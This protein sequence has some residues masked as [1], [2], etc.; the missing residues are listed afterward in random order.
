MRAILAAGGTAG[1]INPAIAIAKEII[2]REPDSVITFIG[3]EDGMESRIVRQNGFGFEPVEIHGFERKLNWAGIKFNLH[4][5][6]CVVTA[7]AKTKKIFREFKPDIVIGCGGYI[8]GPVVRKAAL[9]RIPTVIQEQNSFPGL[10]TRLLSKRVK[11]I[12]VPNED[13]MNKIGYPEKSVIVGNPVAPEIR[14]TDREKSRA[15]LGIGDRTCIVS[16]GGSLGAR[17]INDIALEMFRQTDGDDRF[18][19]IHATG[20]YDST[21]MDRL[22]ENGTEIES[23]PCRISSYINDM[24]R[25]LAA[26]DLVVCR[27]GATTLAEVE[28]AGKAS[29]LVPSPHVTANHQ[30]YNALTLAECG[31]AVLEEEKDLIPSET[32]RCV[33]ELASD[34]DKLAEM[35]KRAAELANYDTA[36]IIYDN[37]KQLLG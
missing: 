35:G 1:H 22:Q 7:T 26:A 2:S 18:F 4:A 30:Y 23:L 10:T 28:A 34:G 14:T 15:E 6:K 36:S 12:F 5:L 3:R 27:S 31:A 37:I 19:F 13:A 24:P 11:K 32:A 17:T 33:L 16:F 9:M 25:C 29:Y 20:A 8:S 21:F